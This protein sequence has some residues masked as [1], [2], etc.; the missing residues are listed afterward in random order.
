MQFLIHFLFSV[1]YTVV[2]WEPLYMLYIWLVLTNMFLFLW[3][4]AM[5]IQLQE[6]TGGHRESNS[7]TVWPSVSSLY[8]KCGQSFIC[9]CSTGDWHCLV[10][11]VKS[12]FIVLTA[13][14]CSS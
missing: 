7:H 5:Y 4:R 2:D 6:P 14:G 3:S 11:P 13:E 9:V 1:L 8:K 10:S 12:L